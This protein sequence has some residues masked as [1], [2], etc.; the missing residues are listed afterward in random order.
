MLE[1][2]KVTLACDTE[3]DAS[4]ALPA[5]IPIAHKVHEE[6]VGAKSLEDCWVVDDDVVQAHGKVGAEPDPDNGGEYC[7]N[8]FGSIA[9][10]KEEKHQDSNG[11]AVNRSTRKA[12]HWDLQALTG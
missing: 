10:D 8:K 7:S 3:Q 11:H 9:L 12:G 2:R 1:V 6:V 4:Q 5:S